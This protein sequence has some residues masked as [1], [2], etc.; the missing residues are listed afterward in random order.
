MQQVRRIADEGGREVPCV[1]LTAFANEAARRRA[2][3][4][5]FAAHLSKPL[6]PDE[7]VKVIRPLIH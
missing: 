4:T 1:A 7:L 6:N 3:S 5:G 2:I